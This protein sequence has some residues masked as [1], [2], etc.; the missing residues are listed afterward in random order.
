MSHTDTDKS[1]LRQEMRLYL[2]GVVDTISAKSRLIRYRLL[3]LDAF[4][5][6]LLSERLMNFVSMPTEINTM[7]FFSGRSMIVPYCEGK[8]IVP[9]RILSLSELEPSGNLKILEPKLAVRQDGLRQVLPEQIGVAL[10]PGLAFDPL[11]NRLGRGWGYYDRL[12]SRLPESVLTIGLALDGM[13]RTQIPHGENDC[14]VKMV[15]TES[16]IMKRNRERKVQ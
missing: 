10:V 13:I 9:I 5:H 16:R 3:T 4:R 7:P 14:P 1:N 8:E 2:K 11:G 6:A 12:L 15:V